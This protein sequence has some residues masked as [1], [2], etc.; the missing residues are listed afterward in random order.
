MPVTASPEDQRIPL[1][2]LRR[3]ISQSMTRS[4]STAAHFT[5]VEEAHVDELVRLREALKPD[6]EAAGVKLT[7]LPFIMKA[8]V[9]TIREFPY[10]NASMD[11]AA[12]DIVLKG[13]INVGIAVD[14]DAGLTVPVVRDVPGKTIFELAADIAA[15]AGRAR[16]AKSTQEDI[17]DGTFTITSTGKHGGLLAT[18]V[19]NHPEVA[20]LGVHAI[21]E[22]AV[23]RDGEIVVGHVMNLSLS[24]DHR[25]V[26][27]MTGAR[28]LARLIG[29]LE[30]PG[31][32]LTALR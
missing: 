3:L 7:Y 28:F 24:L 27:G 8:L 20:I 17:T 11:D 21:R 25:V 31:R 26:D 13:A 16:E 23:V 5:L 29:Y 12:G 14:T 22:R 4:K 6:A 19:I 15:V 30:E 32:L 10:L 18:P 1:R 9:P 2:G